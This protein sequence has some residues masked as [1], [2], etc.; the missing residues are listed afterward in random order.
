VGYILPVV[1]QTSP[2]PILSVIAMPSKLTQAAREDIELQLQYGTRVDVI[3]TAFRIS[4]SQV[5][6]MRENIRMF[7]CVAPDPAQFQVQGRPRLV[8]PEAR[9]GV[10]EF[11]LDNGKLAYI[12]EVKYYLEEEWGIE[13]SLMTAQRL[14]KSLEMTKKVVSYSLSIKAPLTNTLAHR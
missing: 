6:K 2:A 4:I 11:L 3:A 8:T 13:V 7:G 9:E 14:I 5:Y 1:T 12:D 10:L